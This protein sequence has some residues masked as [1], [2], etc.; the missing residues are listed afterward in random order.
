[1]GE[2]QLCNKSFL[3]RSGEKEWPVAIL[4]FGISIFAAGKEIWIG[5]I[6]NYL[7]FK[8]VYL[9]LTAQQPLF[10]FYPEQYHDVN[11]YGPVFSLI[12]AP[13][14]MLPDPVG[15]LLWAIAN[16]AFL[17]Y[18]IR[19]LPLTRIQQNFILLFCS[20]E[21]FGASSYLQFN[22]GIA[23]CIMLSFALILKGKDFWAA[24][25]IILG[26]L[27]KLYGIV[28]LAFFFFSDNRWALIKGLFFW[29][30][31]FFLLPMLLS[32]PIYIL[33]T[34]EQWAEA[35]VVKN[36]KNVQGAL[37]QDISAM[38]FIRR[39]F[40]LQNMPNSWVIIPAIVIFASQY[41][42][43]PWRQNN[44]YRLYILCSTLLFP[45]LFSSSSEAAT[46]IIAFPAVCIWYVIQTPAKWKTAVFI[47]AL[48]FCSFAHS[49]LVTPW[50]RQ[51]ISVRYAIKALPCLLIWL[52]I[53]YQ[54]LTKSF[55][56][57][58]NK[59][60]QALIY[61]QTNQ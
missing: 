28:G 39:T 17:Y 44:T 52:I 50:V 47:F 9:H 32:S 8:H 19:Q 38:G 34:Y 27:T 11:L 30:I 21:L 45:L 53:A 36:D 42:M 59:K 29:G 56:H 23:A 40:N 10:L 48:I 18:A 46:Y 35:L 13:F 6:N 55:L 61:L 2:L 43:L 41:I 16:T 26:T 12:I 49:D 5:K 25:L 57:K 7:I 14:S 20:N 3:I 51:H 54:V 22:Q 60:E 33:Q 1:M 31:V 24:A 37:L 15:A 4:W 58:G